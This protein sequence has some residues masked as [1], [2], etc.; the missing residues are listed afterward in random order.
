MASREPLIPAI[1]Q[2]SGVLAVQGKRFRV[3]VQA[4]GN[5]QQAE[6]PKESSNV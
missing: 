2:N 1:L 5:H 6:W 3:E 4:A